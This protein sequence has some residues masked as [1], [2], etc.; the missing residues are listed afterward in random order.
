M[1]SVVLVSWIYGLSGLF[2]RR[3]VHLTVALTLRSQEAQ[4]GRASTRF[5]GR[6]A[7]DQIIPVHLECHLSGF[8]KRGAFWRVRVG[9][10]CHLR[11][12]LQMVRQLFPLDG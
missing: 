8:P 3:K 2:A 10:G 1:R 9:K 7:H 11:G 12:G 4:A 5:P 6:A